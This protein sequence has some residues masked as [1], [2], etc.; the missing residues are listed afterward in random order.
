MSDSADSS[1]IQLSKI[2]NLIVGTED[3]IKF[4]RMYATKVKQSTKWHTNYL[5]GSQC[6]GLRLEG[7]DVD[8]MYVH[9]HL[10][11]L[12]TLCGDATD[13]TLPTNCL[14]AYCSPSSSA[15]IC[16]EMHIQLHDLLNTRQHLF[17]ALCHSVIYYK[18]ILMAS[19]SLFLQ[20][21]IR[22]GDGDVVGPSQ[23]NAMPMN[24]DNDNVEAFHCKTFPLVANEWI[25]RKR[26]YS[27]P[28]PHLIQLV[29]KLGYHLVPI[30]DYNTTMNQFQW[31]ISF[32]LQECLLV[33]AFSHVQM[34]VYA[35]MKMMKSEV[36]SVYKSQQTGDP[37][38]TSYHIKTLM[39]WTIECVPKYLWC[40]QN[41][42]L[43][44]QICIGS[45]KCFVKSNFMPHYFMPQC[46]LF[47]KHVSKDRH[48]IINALSKY[49]KN[50][51]TVIAMMTK[52][53]DIVRIVQNNYVLPSYHTHRELMFHTRGISFCSN[54]PM[55]VTLVLL[56][57]VHKMNDCDW[58]LTYGLLLNSMLNFK[59]RIETQPS[60][61]V[62]SLYKHYR[63]VKQISLRYTHL[64][65]STGWLLLS[66]Y[67]YQIHNYEECGKL[68][69][70]KV[71]LPITE[72]P[73]VVYCGIF[74]DPNQLKYALT[75]EYGRMSISQL[76]K[77]LACC[78]FRLHNSLVPCELNIETNLYLEK[79]IN[80]VPFL[81]LTYA[82]LLSFLCS[83]H[84]HDVRLQCTTLHHLQSTL[85]DKH[86]GPIGSFEYVHTLNMIG[87]CFELMGDVSN[88]AY[89]YRLSDTNCI[90]FIASEA[91]NIRLQLLMIQNNIYN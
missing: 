62:K 24:I 89:Y 8:L 68:T 77:H 31:R 11:V 83:Y 57:T 53:M 64:D 37:L 72:L 20:H 1:S 36:L 27:W 19:S 49:A 75:R 44:I 26:K 79:G 45:L 88:A 9:N 67:L 30:G 55:T 33:R 76:F 51:S 48:D 66:S 86:S 74:L 46:N 7:S 2:L 23:M 73:H 69:I 91:A 42:I 16:L 63:K 39:F 13:V 85:N 6:D 5:I 87:I 78:S 82:Y 4:M 65:I 80:S 38:I 15:Y 47:K 28:S 21:Y 35:F 71:I 10:P 17:D 84:L 18:D 50:P 52:V 12:D 22:I 43:C 70:E 41:L 32:V 90:P 3:S 60:G 14:I 25:H 54:N 58:F 29:K 59:Q 34:K 81:P 56:T 61:G 40:G